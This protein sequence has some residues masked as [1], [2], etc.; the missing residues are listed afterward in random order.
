MAIVAPGEAGRMAR[1]GQFGVL[2]YTNK[3]EKMTY[4][5]LAKLTS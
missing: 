1:S 3:L 2:K 4:H 5:Q